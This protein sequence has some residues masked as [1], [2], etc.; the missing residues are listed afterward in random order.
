VRKGI[1]GEWRSELSDAQ[2]ASA[3]RMARRELQRFG[4]TRQGDYEASDICLASR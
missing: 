3:W 2:A 1:V 4:Y